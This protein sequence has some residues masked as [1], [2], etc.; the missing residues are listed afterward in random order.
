ML[1]IAIVRLIVAL[2]PLRVSVA[3]FVAILGERQT[4]G[5]HRQAGKRGKYA[6][7]FH[8]LHFGNDT[9]SRNQDANIKCERSL[10]LCAARRSA[11]LRTCTIGC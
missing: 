4:A 3:I 11:P 7:V 10:L 1:V 6:Y 5:R 9:D 8:E 2:L